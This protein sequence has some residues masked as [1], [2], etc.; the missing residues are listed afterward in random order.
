M[1]RD[2]IYAMCHD[3]GKSLCAQVRIQ[4]KES[5]L[6]SKGCRE[7]MSGVGIADG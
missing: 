6:M 5:A 4:I 3:Q 7:Y 1:R 2:V